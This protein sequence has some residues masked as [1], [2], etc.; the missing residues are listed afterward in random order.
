[1]FVPLFKKIVCGFLFICLFGHFD[2]LASTKLNP[3]LSDDEI[4]KVI[5]QRIDREKQGVGLVVGVI[6]EQGARVIS[7]GRFGQ[8][9]QRL[10]D[11]ASIFELGSVTK[12]FTSLLLADMANKG[13]LKLT[14]P[15]AD[16]LPKHVKMPSRNGKQITFLDLANHTSG[17][18][19]WP[20][21][22]VS[23]DPLN[24]IA[25]YTVQQMYEFLSRFQLT[26]DIGEKTEYSNV[27]VGLLGHVLTLIGHKDFDSLVKER[28]TVPLGM[29]DTGVMMTARMTENLTRPHDLQGNP[30]KNWDLPAMPGAG[31]LRSSANDM[32]KFL[33]ANMHPDSSSVG[34][35]VKRMQMPFSEAPE[36]TLAWSVHSK[37]GTTVMKHSG[38]TFGYKSMIIFDRSGRRGI[39]I[40]SNSGDVID[41]GHHFINRE[42]RLRQYLPPEE[43]VLAL[44]QKGFSSA[45]EIYEHLRKTNQN[46]YL[47]EDVLNEWAYGLLGSNKNDDAISIFKLGVYLFPKSV[48]AY[49]S[50]AEAYEKVGD[51]TNAILNYEKCLTLDPISEHAQQRLTL[52][53][54]K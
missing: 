5:Q 42:W 36:T 50:L 10:V 9:S 2:V 30:V 28:I 20:D 33:A 25:D 35:A 41:L 39:V 29:Y 15:V 3:L 43:F 51:L 32:L 1:M 11:G 45:I 22:L 47:R 19:E 14:D 46:F 8:Q 37:Y 12:L 26:R 48:N 24:P 16:Y 34:A 13:E 21:N 52:L 49:D 23:K 31:A 7:Y 40:L 54:K 27:G 38:S 18:P 17:L 53:R 6:D 44:E 4:L